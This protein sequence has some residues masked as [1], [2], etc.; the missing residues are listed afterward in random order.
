MIRVLFFGRLQDDLGLRSLEWE[1]AGSVEQ[2]RLLIAHQ[3]APAGEA[4]L[5]PGVRA[6]INQ[7]LVGEA[8]MVVSGDELAFLPPVTGG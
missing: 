4:L 6:A 5:S 8:A 3:F 1:G 2:L 7:T